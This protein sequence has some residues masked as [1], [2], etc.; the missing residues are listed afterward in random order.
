MQGQ[1]VELAA[2][3]VVLAMLAAA[4][5]ADLR[6]GKIPNWIT[7]PGAAVGIA[8][9][10]AGAGLPGLADRLCGMG[11]VLVAVLLLSRAA[12]LGGG[13]IKLLMAVGALK[14]FHFALWAMLLTG[15]F[16]GLVAAV[17][18]LRRRAMKETALNLMVAAMLPNTGGPSTTIPAAP[19][20]AKIP[21]SIAIALGSLSALGLGM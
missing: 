13:D 7:A 16:G 10:A 18:V 21:Y 14:G 9:G 15:V 4:L 11:A 3:A 19:A 17:V 5:L 6:T 2:I 20:A 8:L 12:R 1:L